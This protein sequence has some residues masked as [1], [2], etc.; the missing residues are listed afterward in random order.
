MTATAKRHSGS[1]SA[2]TPAGDMDTVIVASS[3]S[4]FCLA[5]RCT[6]EWMLHILVI[7][8]RSFEAQV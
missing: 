7:R 1:P 8:R 4:F 2:S 5:R 6:C 3:R